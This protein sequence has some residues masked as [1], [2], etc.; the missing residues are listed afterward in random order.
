MSGLCCRQIPRMYN[1]GLASRVQNEESEFA[2]EKCGIASRQTCLAARESFTSANDFH[3]KQNLSST[4]PAARLATPNAWLI[5]WAQ[6]G[7]ACIAVRA[8]E[9]A[10]R[11]IGGAR[12]CWTDLSS[13]ASRAFTNAHSGK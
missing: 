6:I 11:T 13:T 7:G 8:Q 1:R 5:A 4:R 2:R 12:I 10:A 3:N 9:Q